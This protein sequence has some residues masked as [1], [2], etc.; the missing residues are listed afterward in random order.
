MKITIYADAAAALA[1]KE[2]AENFL[3]SQG[4]A[5]EIEIVCQ[6]LLM[7]PWPALEADGAVLASGLHF[8]IEKT[9]QLLLQAL[10]SE[11]E[12]SQID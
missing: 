11:E 1:I 10:A 5:G 6:G 12:A 4:L 9:E 7:P 2:A 8:S 3:T